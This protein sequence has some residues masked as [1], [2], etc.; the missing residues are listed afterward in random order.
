M[1][2]RNIDCSER[3]IEVI[4]E[5]GIIPLF[6]SAVPGW[7]IEDL[8]VPGCW[9]DDNDEGILG[10]WDWKVDAVQQGDIAYGKFLGGKAGFA[11]PQWYAHL[12]N[13]RRSI[14][15]YRIAEGGRY[16][17]ATNSEKLMKI[18]S[19]V[20][21]QAIRDA[22][23]LG[24]KEIRLIC[25]SKITESQIRSMGASY[26]KLLSPTIKKNVMDSTLQFLQMGTWSLVGDI[27]RV[28][29]GPELKYSGW[30]LASN[31]TPEALFGK[32]S[33]TVSE[34]PSAA[35]PSWAKRFEEPSEQA[36]RLPDCSP[37]ESR[38]ALIDHV[39]SIFPDADRSSLVKIF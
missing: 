39:R 23:A 22:G 14:P 37:K 36:F 6:R 8:T 2:S 1:F 7:S 26:K 31:T 30:Q 9:F 32:A 28:Y 19:P 25:S 16:K 33:N 18:L 34:V 13:W 10:P 35:A 27:E 11:T 29:R 24:S 4:R 21:L 12:M 15:K 3:M 5:A 17:A 38:E 20:A